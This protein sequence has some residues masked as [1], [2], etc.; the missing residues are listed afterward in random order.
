MNK[1]GSFGTTTI[2]ITFGNEA[3]QAIFDC[4][5]LIVLCIVCMIADLWWAYSEHTYWVAH[6][7]TA[8]EKAKHVW[9]KSRAIRRTAMKLVDYIT[10]MLVGMVIGLAVCE[11]FDIASHTTS[12]AIGGL[13]GVASD[14]V[15]IVGHICVVR[16]INIKKDFVRRFFVALVKTKNE[17]IGNALDKSFNNK[18][19]DK[20]S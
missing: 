14:V 8:E 20:V 7:K 13:I 17:E 10:L 5:W 2:W 4:R 6:S 12:A 18:D 9:R 1:T 3:L 16:E 19:D 11:P 15:S